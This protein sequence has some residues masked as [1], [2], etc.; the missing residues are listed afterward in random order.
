[1]I[2]VIFVIYLILFLNIKKGTTIF[3]LPFRY[4]Q[5][6][7]EI[8][9]IDDTTYFVLLGILIM[10]GIGALLEINQD[11]MKNSADK[12]KSRDYSSRKKNLSSNNL[13]LNKNNLT[14]EKLI[15]MRSANL[16]TDEEFLNIKKRL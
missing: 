9:N 3:D 16:I 1:M 12:S 7:E 8:Y 14:L 6:K 4:I 5:I 15:E 11:F 10:L 13:V 2:T